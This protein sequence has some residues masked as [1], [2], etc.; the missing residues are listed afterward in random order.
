MRAEDE[1]LAAHHVVP[2]LHAVRAEAVADPVVGG[3]DAEPGDVAEI[4]L[5]RFRLHDR[6]RHQ[7]G[8]ERRRST[9]PSRGSVASRLRTAESEPAPGAFCT[10]TFGIAGNVLADV[11]RDARG[12]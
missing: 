9:V 5:D 2:G 6:L 10:M 4:D 7:A 11:A 1:L 12:R 3:D 8:I